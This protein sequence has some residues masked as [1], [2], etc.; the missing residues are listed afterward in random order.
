MRL[1]RILCATDFSPQAKVALE[2]AAELSSRLGAPLLL[3]AAF[4]IPIYPLPE[5]VM[6]RTSETISQLLAQ[7]SND[8]AAA[9][10]SASEAGALEVE[11]VVVEGN[12]ASEI[13]RVAAERGIDLIVLGS[14]GRGGISRAILGSVADKVMRTAACPVLIVAHGGPDHP[15]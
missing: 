3:L 13:V 9:R 8:L 12:P 10:L 7:T 4:Q 2:Y 14:H 15:G 11:T 1:Q 6:V 5:G